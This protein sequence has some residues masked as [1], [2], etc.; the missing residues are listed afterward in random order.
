M[1]ENT[2]G[3]VRDWVLSLV[4]NG[5]GIKATASALSLNRGTVQSWVARYRGKKEIRKRR[6]RFSFPQARS[7]EEWLNALRSETVEPKDSGAFAGRAVYLVCGATNTKGGADNLAAIVLGRLKS[8]AS[9]GGVYVFC[10]AECG[11]A[12]L[13]LWDAGG[14]SLLTRRREFGAYPWPSRQVG[15]VVKTTSEDLERIMICERKNIGNPSLTRDDVRLPSP[16]KSE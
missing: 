13:L 16:E 11:V 3:E 12:R 4:L 14:F 10:N 15:S 9:D 5:Y 6:A 8:D 1:C 7:A 2:P